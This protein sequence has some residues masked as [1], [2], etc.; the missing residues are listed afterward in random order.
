MVRLGRLGLLTGQ[1]VASAPERDTLCVVDNIG[2]D[3]ALRQR[4]IQER[5]SRG[6]SIRTAAASA[7]PGRISNTAWAAWE[8]GERDMSPKL[9]TAIAAAFDWPTDWINQTTTAE[10]GTAATPPPS[11]LLA[12]VGRLAD[13]VRQQREQLA[14]VLQVLQ[15]AGALPPGEVSRRKREARNKT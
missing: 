4:V 6:W 5:R 3:P 7:G 14:A 12:E 10:T 9:Q 1:F 11:D 13:E 15:N 8:N 2:N